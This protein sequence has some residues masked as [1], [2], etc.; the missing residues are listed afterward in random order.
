MT[1]A[2]EAQYGPNELN[3][4]SGSEQVYHEVLR[5]R[6][7]SGKRSGY[8]GGSRYVVNKATP[9]LRKYYGKEQF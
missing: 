9:I 8:R 3:G 4:K 1:N 6:E 2:S 5:G 7:E